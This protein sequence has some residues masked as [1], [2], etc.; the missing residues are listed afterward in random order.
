MK[1]G[2]HPRWQARFGWVLALPIA[3]AVAG[4]DADAPDKADPKQA[5]EA[6]RKVHELGQEVRRLGDWSR[7]ADHIESFIDDLWERN[8]WNT[9][10]DQFARRL[11]HEVTRI[12]P[13]RF[14]GRLDRMSELVADR[15][16]L[17]ARQRIQF[18]AKLFAESVGF[19]AGNADTILRH[20]H[21]YV[22]KRLNGEP[23]TPEVVQRWTNESDPL[24][25]DLMA[26]V[27]RICNSV[28][29]DMTPAQRAKFQRDLESLQRQM[30]FALQRRESWRRGDWK[31]ED[32]GLQ[33]DPIQL[34]HALAREKH[35]PRLADRPTQNRHR[36]TGKTA[37]A[38]RVHE[39]FVAENEST[40]AAYVRIFVARHDLDAGQRDA[41]HSILSELEARAANFRARHAD[42]L[43]AVPKGQR[44]NSAAYQP[45][46]DMFDELQRRAEALLTGTQRA[47]DKNRRHN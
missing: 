33:K 30:Q 38:A 11:N 10:S 22:E 34:G 44:E 40:W 27:D 15:Y 42:E 29:R 20:A 25:A 23:L 1:T 28:S 3:T 36:P 8:G 39:P 24:V 12:P 47:N 17:S 9:E 5:V 6:M 37:I 14:K 46:R 7:H 26:R 13:W 4:P 2:Q 35:D 16:H 45:L 31:P 32:W 18:E 41:I 21:D 43:D 19:V